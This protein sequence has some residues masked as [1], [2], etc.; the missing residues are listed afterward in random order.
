MPKDKKPANTQKPPKEP[1]VKEEGKLHTLFCDHCGE[2]KIFAESIVE[3]KVGKMCGHCLQGTMT[4]AVV[5]QDP[6]ATI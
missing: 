4:L 5:F 2:T 1:E 6:G 3:Q